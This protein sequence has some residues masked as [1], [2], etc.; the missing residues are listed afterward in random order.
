[1]P[2]GSD[3]DE[4]QNP[5]YDFQMNVI[6][7]NFL[8]TLAHNMY[9][10]SVLWDFVIGNIMKISCCQ[11]SSEL[12][13]SGLSNKR[14]EDVF[15]GHFG[16][17]MLRGPEAGENTYGIEDAVICDTWPYLQDLEVKE[18][19]WF[20][21]CKILF[22]QN[23]AG[24]HLEA[25]VTISK[26]QV[27]LG[28]SEEKV[29]LR[30]DATYGTNASEWLWAKRMAM[31]CVVSVHQFQFHLVFDHMTTEAFVA[32]AYKHLYKEHY[33]FRALAP[34]CGDVGFINRA[35]GFNMIVGIPEKGRESSQFSSSKHGPTAAFPFTTNGSITAIRRA[36]RTLTCE[37]YFWFDE[38]GYMKGGCGVK[39]STPFPVRD[40]AR[41]IWDATLKLATSIVSNHWKQSDKHLKR[42]WTDIFWGP[43]KTRQCNMTPENVSEVLATI[44]FNA[45]HRHDF[46]H[47]RYLAENHRFL[48]ATLLNGNQLNPATYLPSQSLHN[49][50][51]V[52]YV[53][54][55]GGNIE[56]PL[57]CFEEAFPEIESVLEYP[58]EISAV[59][60]QSQHLKEIGSMTH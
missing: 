30:T 14:F 20:E 22:H 4:T 11:G 15:I 46:A 18:H 28:F 19:V 52:Q 44:I 29:Y 57:N 5:M 2:T 56:S 39:E 32:L 37:N 10:K 9:E 17:L 54:L 26:E 50:A 13:Q 58:A 43:F 27:Q 53:G 21:P 49:Q 16:G 42:W 59:I 36:K 31:S 24:L 60:Q 12:F 40:D 8:S 6:L 45:T 3:V 33:I 51:V 25:V 34:V 1:V 41:K 35:W 47:S 23:A 48:V 7:P 55:H 38:G